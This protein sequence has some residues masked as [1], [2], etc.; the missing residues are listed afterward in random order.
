M[1][2]QEQGKSEEAG[3]ESKSE[4]RKDKG[5]KFQNLAIVSPFLSF[6]CLCCLYYT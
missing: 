1:S 5:I 6:Y 4:E 3:V 2:K